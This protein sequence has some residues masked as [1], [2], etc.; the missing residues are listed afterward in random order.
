MDANHVLLRGIGE[1]INVEF[2]DRCAD[3]IL[4][5]VG[6]FMNWFTMVSFSIS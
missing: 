4:E 1:T 6:V 3:Y 5:S 2:V